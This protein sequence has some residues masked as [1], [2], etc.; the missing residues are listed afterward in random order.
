[1]PDGSRPK[2]HRRLVRTPFAHLIGYVHLVDSDVRCHEKVTQ[3]NDSVCS[4]VE[5]RCKTSEPKRLFN[6]ERFNPEEVIH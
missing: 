6:D 3:F 2:I 5:S 4:R 1:M